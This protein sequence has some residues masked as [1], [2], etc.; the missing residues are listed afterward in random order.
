M[1]LIIFAF[2]GVLIKKL[3]LKFCSTWVDPRCLG[4]KSQ[5]KLL[6]S[7]WGHTSHTWAATS[8]DNW[9][10]AS[11]STYGWIQ[12]E[13][14]KACTCEIYLQISM[15]FLLK[16]LSWHEEF[17]FLGAIRPK[18]ARKNNLIPGP[19]PASFNSLRQPLVFP[20]QSF[21][22]ENCSK[23]HFWKP[24]RKSP[25]LCLGCTKKQVGSFQ[26]KGSPAVLLLGSLHSLKKHVLITFR[27]EKK[28][29]QIH[30]R[31]PFLFE[32]T[33]TERREGGSIRKEGSL[34]LPSPTINPSSW[35]FLFDK[36]KDGNMDLYGSIFEDFPYDIQICSL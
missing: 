18:F 21:G 14:S 7:C 19:P 3:C 15:E 34:T 29:K 16:G 4:L 36:E 10:V 23:L 28:R 35:S 30:L 1:C 9:Q 25:C 2:L 20:T 26:S 6:R 5:S 8:H 17:A 13:S 11:H 32:R 27:C 12:K 24:I 22:H 33:K 31:T